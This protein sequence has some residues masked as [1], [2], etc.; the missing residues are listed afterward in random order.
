MVKEITTIEEFK[1]V[2]SSDN[3]VIVDF[4]ATWCMPC[5]MF[6]K[7]LEK[8]DENEEYSDITFVKVNVDEAEDLS[9]DQ[10][11]RSLP[12]IRAFKSGSK[13]AEQIGAMDKEGFKN[14][15]ENNK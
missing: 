1:K 6:S 9:A 11:V 7:V 15:I 10:G 3:L 8:F 14:F 2:T 5:K 12:T 4:W 13:V